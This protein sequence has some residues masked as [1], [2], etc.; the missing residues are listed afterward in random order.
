MFGYVYAWMMLL[1]MIAYRLFIH[2][3]ALDGVHF[4]GANIQKCF[5]RSKIGGTS[6]VLSYFSLFFYILTNGVMFN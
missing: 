6:E 2:G 3:L 4:H 5:N 1:M